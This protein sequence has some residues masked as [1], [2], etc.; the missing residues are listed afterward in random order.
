MGTI[1]L[2]PS[3]ILAVSLVAS[4]GVMDTA[5]A[6]S[7]GRAAV[8][9]RSSRS[10]QRAVRSSRSGLSAR[11]PRSAFGVPVVRDA[12]IREWALRD[13]PFGREAIGR[14]LDGRWRRGRRDGLRRR[15]GTHLRGA[16]RPLLRGGCYGG[17]GG[18]HVGVG[19][20]G[21]RVG[22]STG[23]GFASSR[24]RCGHGAGGVLYV[25]YVYSGGGYVYG[26]GRDDYREDDYYEENSSGAAFSGHDPS[27]G[28]VTGCAAVRVHLRRGEWYGGEV[29]LPALGADTPEGLAAALRA[30][31]RH[32]RSTML[33]GFEGLSLAVPAGPG[34][35]AVDVQACG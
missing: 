3:A 17:G 12:P 35:E 32:G 33:E 14:S 30:R 11:S 34:V 31:H 22:V 18:V 9:S 29:R 6:Q 10:F 27:G 5:D 23:Y 26:S 13:S 4:S 28:M 15:A 21:V 24:S 7:R 1:R 25:P 16:A 20:R 19:S 8:S 2:L